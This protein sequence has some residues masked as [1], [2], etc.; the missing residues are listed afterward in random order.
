M[1]NMHSQGGV[2]QGVVERANVGIDVSKHRLDVCCRDEHWQFDNDA[3]GW[4]ELAARLRAQEADLVVVEATGGYE[5]G[6]VCVL[7][8]AGLSVVRINPRQSHDF[9]KSM[10]VLAK[11]DR[12]DARV[13]CDFADVLARHAQRQRYLTPMAD[14]ARLQLAELMTR[15][16]QLLEMQGAEHNRLEH[17]GARAV[18]SIRSVLKLLERQLE[19]ID[20]DIDDHLDRHFKPQ[21][22]LLDTVKGIGTVSILTLMAVM[23]ELGHL[24]RRQIAK[25][26][27]VAPLAHDSGRRQGQ[28]RIWGGRAEVRAVLFM[29]VRSAVRWN[30]VIRA[31]FERLIKAGKPQKVARVACIRKLLTILNAML[32]DQTAW[33]VARYLTQPRAA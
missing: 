17:A 7:Q 10:G 15:R 19:R 3:R 9:A 26:A 18:R 4:D 22:E 21:R 32:R 23:P 33:D 1:M 12:V 11:T 27:G 25:L 28:R 29:A 6:V 20:R 2:A 13:L 8:D 5:R 31:F 30:P 14:T 16:R 24:G